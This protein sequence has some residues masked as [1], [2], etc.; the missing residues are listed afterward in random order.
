[1]TEQNIN[2]SGKASDANNQ[3]S[4][5]K[6]GPEFSCCDPEVTAAKIECP[7]A[8]FFKKHPLMGLGI[9]SIMLLMFLISQVGGILGIIAFIRTL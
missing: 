3:D 6:S 9:F 8:S 2:N 4:Q 5:A 1:M 7:C